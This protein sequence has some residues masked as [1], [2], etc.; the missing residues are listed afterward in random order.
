LSGKLSGRDTT[1]LLDTGAS[2]TVVDVETARAM[3]LGLAPLSETGGGAG[4]ARLDLW[5]LDVELELEGRVVTPAEGIFAM[6]LSHVI[7]ALKARG[8]NPPAVILGADV[9]IPRRA[10]IDFG[11]RALYLRERIDAIAA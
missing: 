9:L 11:E 10:I 5:K 3:G 6:D 2:T 1:V 8:V 7:A 4:A